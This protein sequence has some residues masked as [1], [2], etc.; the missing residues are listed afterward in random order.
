MQ[1]IITKNFTAKDKFN[2]SGADGLKNHKD[3]VL[4]ITDVLVGDFPDKD[5]NIVTNAVLKDNEGKLYCSISQAV[6]KSAIALA[7]IFETEDS[8]DVI[9]RAKQSGNKREYLI[10]ELA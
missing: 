4:T 5:G 8:V 10:L 1:T 6:V 3:E 9:A 7:E 2:I